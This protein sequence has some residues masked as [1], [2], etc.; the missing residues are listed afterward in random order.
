MKAWMRRAADLRSEQSYRMMKYQAF[1]WGFVDG[2]D[3]LSFVL[4]EDTIVLS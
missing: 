4:H 1:G 2:N 3:C